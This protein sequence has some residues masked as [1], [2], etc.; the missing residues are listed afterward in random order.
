MVGEPVEVVQRAETSCKRTL[1]GKIRFQRAV[2]NIQTEG[3]PVTTT[4][5]A[6]PGT[7]D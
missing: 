7:R 5:I 3:S 6:C 1:T 2:D 4:T